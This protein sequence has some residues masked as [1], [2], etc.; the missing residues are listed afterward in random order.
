MLTEKLQ[1]DEPLFINL[2]PMIDVILTLLIFF[3]AATKL[4]DWNEQKL[5]VQLPEVGAAKPITEAPAEII[6]RISQ[7]GAIDYNGEPV[8]LS[9]MTRRLGAARENY[10][11]QGVEIR[12]DGRVPFRKVAEVMSGCES[13]G[14]GQIA[15]HVRESVGEQD[16]R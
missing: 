15:V 11:D 3:M 4:Y 7:E 16:S 13:A 8:G 10:P 5:D 12:G 6:L 9:E 14:I 1:Q 2:T